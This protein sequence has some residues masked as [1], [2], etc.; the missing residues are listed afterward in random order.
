MSGVNVADHWPI[1][2]AED[3]RDALL[4]AYGEPK[5]GYHDLRHLAEVLDR[6]DELASAGESF[7]ALPVVLAAWFHDAVYDGAPG[8]EERSARWAEGALP[9]AGVAAEVVAEVARLVGLTVSHDPAPADR[10][11]AALCD[12]DLAIL[13][14]PSERYAEYVADV[15]LEYAHVPDSEFRAGRAAVL[16][17]LA[18]GP[19][20]VTSYG[21][22]HW[23]R[24]ARA[25][26][27]AEL[28][29][30]ES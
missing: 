28:T 15:R 19:L 10:N 20:Y 26:L 12:A 18:E 17:A 6:L 11:G 4:A 3:V 21:R 13:A 1:D 14:A 16:R 22:A 2:G 27:E 23:E 8:D 9:Q 7:D 29:R 25:N 30:L 24:S 5:R